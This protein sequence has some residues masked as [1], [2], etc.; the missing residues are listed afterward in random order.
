[1]SAEKE[2][3]NYWCNEKGLFTVNNIK[4]PGN[5]DCGILALKFEKDK[6]DEIIHVE[7]SC[8]ITSTIGESNNIEKSVSK[9]ISDK[10]ENK[11]VMEALSNYTKQLPASSK[12]KR[13]MVLGAIPK[14]RKNDIIKSF[15]ENNVEI[16]EF[17][18]ILYEV[19]EKLGT[20]YHKNDIIRTMQLIKF[21]LLSEP[22]KMAKMLVNDNFTTGSRKEFLMSI[23]D[24]DEIV[25]EFKKTNVERL[26]AIMKNANLKPDELAKMIGH[27]L[28][29]SR[30]RKQFYDSMMEQESNRNSA[31]KTTRIRKKN[32]ALAKF[33]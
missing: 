19:L 31:S 13:M 33:F 9:I 32:V 7:V 20:Q 14:T 22:E 8:S 1:M 16:I 10:F 30:T 4:A 2:I 21:L 18:D 23:L 3:V 6:V 27:D 11:S 12:L 17:E 25:K 15:M 24:K 26:G 5:R 29:N 28:L